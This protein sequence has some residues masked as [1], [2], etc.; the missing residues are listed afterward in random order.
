MVDAEGK[1]PKVISQ[2]LEEFRREDLP[3]K[4]KLAVLIAVLLYLLGAAASKGAK[5]Q[6]IANLSII[7]FYFLRHVGWYT[8][9]KTSEH[10]CTKQFRVNDVVLRSNNKCLN[11]APPEWFLIIRCCISATL[12]ISSQKNGNHS[13][14]IHH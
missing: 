5:E 4:P 10:W 12:T 9:H 2:I 1:Y 13:Q 11:S 6:A 7:T 8:Y 3:T 14:V